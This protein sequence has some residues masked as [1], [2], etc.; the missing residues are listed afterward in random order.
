VGKGSIT[1]LP[2]VAL[3]KKYLTGTT[4]AS[5]PQL[6][7]PFVG[8]VAVPGSLTVPDEDLHHG[9]GDGEMTG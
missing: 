1:V 6:R 4:E 2:A 8:L 3:V 5:F 7:L 9:A